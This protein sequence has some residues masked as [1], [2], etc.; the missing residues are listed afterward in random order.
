[1]GDLGGGFYPDY[2]IKLA[3]SFLWVIHSPSIGSEA[4]TTTCTWSMEVRWG[5]VGLGW[6]GDVKRFVTKL[7][8]LEEQIFRSY[9]IPPYLSPLL[10]AVEFCGRGV[11]RT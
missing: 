5:W 1:M 2:W 9:V 6:V 8:M 10:L 3:T 7:A 4:C 11:A